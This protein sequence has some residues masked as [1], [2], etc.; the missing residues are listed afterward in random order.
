MI[1]KYKILLVLAFGISAVVSNANAENITQAGEKSIKEF[2][3]CNKESQKSYN[4]CTK[5]CRKNYKE[6]EERYECV[7]QCQDDLKKSFDACG[8]NKPDEKN[9][10]K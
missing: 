10:S 6:D 4:A 9:N 5:K 1:G 2:E 3:R 8:E 7:L